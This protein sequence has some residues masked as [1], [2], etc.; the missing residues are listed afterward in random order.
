MEAAE[1]QRMSPTERLQAMELLWDSLA[2]DAA[3]VPSPEWHA[4]V[5]KERLARVEQGQGRFISLDE[6]KTR[7]GR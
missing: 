1:I 2:K 4:D 5:L 6:A 7:L 3:S